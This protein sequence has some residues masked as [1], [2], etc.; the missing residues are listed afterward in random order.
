[1]TRRGFWF[2]NHIHN[3][4]QTIL[5]QVLNGS[6]RLERDSA[7]F[8]LTVLQYTGG[9]GRIVSNVSFGPSLKL[10]LDSPMLQYTLNHRYVTSINLVN[11][12]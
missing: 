6:K 7:I 4:E 2:A 10:A 9:K 3:R 5:F 12:V 8:N 1:M 11:I